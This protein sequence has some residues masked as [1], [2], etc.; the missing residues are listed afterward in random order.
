MCILKADHICKNYRTAGI[1]YPVLKD[2]SLQINKGEI[3]AI[4]GPSGSGKTTLLNVLS[5]VDSSDS[6]E[7]WIGERDLTKLSPEESARFRR[8]HFGMVFQDFQLLESLSVRE[9]ILL[10][11]ILESEDG[12]VQEQK[13]KEM[14]SVLRIE[15]LAEKGITEISGG[16]KQRTAIARAFIHNPEL[17]FADEPTGN[18][19]VKS[20][21]DVMRCMVHMNETFGTSII[22]VTHD[23]YVAS[24]CHRVLLLKDGNFIC[25]IKRNQQ[26]FREDLIKMLYLSGGEQNDV[27]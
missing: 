10:P 2:V 8:Q 16:Q 4:M 22:V 11:L 24:F 9:N 5:G 6:G 3:V 23:V 19:D 26:S 25:E 13:L 1:S 18:L 20:T 21:R 17:I 7:I 12:E 15:P 14:L 27:F